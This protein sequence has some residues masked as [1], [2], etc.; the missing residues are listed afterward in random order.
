MNEIE[1]SGDKDLQ[2]G[3]ATSLML[4]GLTEGGVFREEVTIVWQLNSRKQT[5]R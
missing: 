5:D 2:F 4:G 1:D 3:P